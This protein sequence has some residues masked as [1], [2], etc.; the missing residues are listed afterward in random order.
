VAG[1]RVLANSGASTA[2]LRE[3]GV[4]MQKRI[5]LCFGFGLVGVAALAVSGCGGKAPSAVKPMEIASDAG[6]QAIKKYDK[7]HDDALDYEELAK[8]PGL[9]AGVAKIKNLTTFHG[10]KPSPEKL[11][12]QLK[13]AKITAE[14]IDARIA[15]WK[16]Y[17]AGRISVSCRVYRKQGGGKPQPLAGAEVKLVPEDFL[18]PG[19]TTG[20][21]T[22]DK[23]G[24]ANVSQPSQDVPPA[25]GMSPGYYRVEITKAGENIPPKY[26]KDTT[27]GVEVASD[28][29]DLEGGGMKFELEY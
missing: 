19:L 5:G 28:S 29:P 18:G 2:I 1:W 13:S 12:E 10:P 26:N 21:G 6:T 22:T 17:P 23:N 25:P 24:S 7:N 20:T 8:A 15:E 16:K 11:K 4:L 3:K 14:E 27:L 9:R